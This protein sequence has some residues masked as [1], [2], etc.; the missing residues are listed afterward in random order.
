[1]LRFAR[2]DT[3]HFNLDKVLVSRCAGPNE[4]AIDGIAVLSVFH[5]F[6][7]PLDKQAKPS[8]GALERLNNTIVAASGNPQTFTD[9]LDCLVMV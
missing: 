4:C 8:V 7:V 1:L 5:L 6:G 9:F 3:H 2:N